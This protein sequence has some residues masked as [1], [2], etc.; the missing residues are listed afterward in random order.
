MAR[1]VVFCFALRLS[2]SYSKPS[3]G[4][5]FAEADNRTT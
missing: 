2:L 4:I 3:A 5:Q 1:V